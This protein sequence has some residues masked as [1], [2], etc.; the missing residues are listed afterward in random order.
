MLA[1]RVIF[2][3]SP[4]ARCPDYHRMTSCLVDNNFKWPNNK[5]SSVISQPGINKVHPAYCVSECL[6]CTLWIHLTLAVSLLCPALCDNAWSCIRGL[7]ASQQSEAQD[8]L[9]G[10]HLSSNKLNVC[11]ECRAERTAIC[12]LRPWLNPCCSGPVN[13][14][15]PQLQ[16][17]LHDRASVHENEMRM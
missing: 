6:W 15:Q 3:C 14:P 8:E 2:S 9:P 10:S 12:E 1:S 17:C 13:T 16:Q 5:S 4:L 11:A 7:Q